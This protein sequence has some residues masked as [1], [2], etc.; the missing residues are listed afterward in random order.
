MISPSVR[1]VGIGCRHR[2]SATVARMFE[3]RSLL[4]IIRLHNGGDVSGTVE[5]LVRGNIDLVDVTL[6]TPGALGAA[7]ARA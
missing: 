1:T 7:A 2:A 5:A 4:G 6:D 3:S